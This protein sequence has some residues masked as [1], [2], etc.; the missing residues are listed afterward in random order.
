MPEE[1]NAPRSPGRAR[2][3]EGGEAGR[4]RIPAREEVLAWLGDV[5]RGE[6]DAQGEAPGAVQRM[7]AAELLAKHYGL[8][9]GPALE[10]EGDAGALQALA[11]ALERAREAYGS[12]GV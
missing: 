9:D 10:R 7:K 5:M 11:E 8:L 12:D 2:P 1:L 3:A 4:Y 6:P